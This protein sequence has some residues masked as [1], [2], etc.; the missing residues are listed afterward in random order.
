M[1]RLWL[2]MLIS[3]GQSVCAVCPPVYISPLLSSPRLSPPLPVYC[4][5]SLPLSVCICFF[6]P[7]FSAVSRL[8]CFLA[9]FRF[10]FLFCP[11]MHLCNY[12]CLS[13]CNCYLFLFSSFFVFILFLY[14]SAL[15]H[16]RFSSLLI[17]VASS[18]VIFFMF[19]CYFLCFCSLLTLFIRLILLLFDFCFSSSRL[20]FFLFLIFLFSLMLFYL[21]FLIHHFFCF[22]PTVA[23]F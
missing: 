16:F 9:L 4:F 18:S 6:L 17:L 19:F 11:F 8:F 3:G 21:H 2:A 7:F 1:L 12:L 5:T 10:V 14:Y 20:V 15:G 23:L 13:L 22:L